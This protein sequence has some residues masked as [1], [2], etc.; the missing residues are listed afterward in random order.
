YGTLPG[1]GEVDISGTAGVAPRRADVRVRARA[2]ALPF[3]GR[4][5]PFEARVTGVGTVDVR[6]VATLEKAFGATVTG[7]VVLDNVTVGD[8][9][10]TPVPLKR[11]IAKGLAYTYPVSVRVADLTLTEPST[12][13]E[14]NADGSLN[15]A[16]LARRRAIEAATP[17]GG[18]PAA[19]ADTVPAVTVGVTRLAV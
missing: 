5:L 17:P 4:H 14:R 9:V 7:D 16:A 12:V 6:V 1:V 8:G 18:T 3:L 19:S 15:L 11:V 13:V 10:Q 2:L